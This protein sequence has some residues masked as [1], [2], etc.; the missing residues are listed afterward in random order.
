MTITTKFKGDIEGYELQIDGGVVT[1]L[2]PTA[3]SQGV[4]VEIR[5]IF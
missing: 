4:N 5:F 3:C 1:S 2:K